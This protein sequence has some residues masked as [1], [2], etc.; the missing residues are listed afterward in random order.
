M[1]ILAESMKMMHPMLS[2]LTE[3]IWSKLPNTEDKVISAHFPEYL[4]AR[5]Y[6]EE[7]RMMVSMQDLVRGVRNMRAELGIGAERKL[8]MV[9]RV[10]SGAGLAAFMK[11]HVELL[12]VFANA[13]DLKIDDSASCDVTGA[14][15]VAGQGFETYVFVRDAIDVDKEISR[16]EGDIAKTRALLDVVEKKLSNEKFMSNAKQEAIDK[17]L[18]KKAEFEEKI[19]KSL[20]HIEVLRSF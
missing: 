7:A 20:K 12:K 13:D 17:E 18:A 4:E 14:F 9:V 10:D 5:K 16:L 19:G 15:P 2:F 1:D 3:E 6:P 8:R 11:D